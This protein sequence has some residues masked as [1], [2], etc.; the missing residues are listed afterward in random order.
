MKGYV[1]TA[2]L[3]AV[4][5]ALSIAS[6]S[7][8]ADARDSVVCKQNSILGQSK[9]P[10]HGMAKLLARKKWRSNAGPGWNNWTLAKNRSATC[11]KD[12]NLWS[13]SNRARPCRKLGGVAK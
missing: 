4:I 8:S 12:G 6:L 13:C 10:V 7:G 5:A 2:A 11:R 3:A 1:A 9:R